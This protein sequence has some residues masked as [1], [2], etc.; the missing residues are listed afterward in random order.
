M[1]GNKVADINKLLTIKQTNYEK[2]Q[3]QNYH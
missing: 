3:T 1:T 2:N